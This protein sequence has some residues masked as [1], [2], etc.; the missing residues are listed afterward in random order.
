MSALPKQKFVIREAHP[1]DAHHL[2]RFVHSASYGLAHHY[3]QS[4]APEGTDPFEIG[5]ERAR[6]ETGS[7]SYRNAHVAER[8][9]QVVA[10]MIGYE[11]GTEPEEID[12][13]EIPAIFV[14]LVELENRALNSFY[15]NVLATDEAYQ[16]LGIGSQLLALAAELAPGKQLSLIC[17][18]GNPNAQKLYER[19][20]FSVQATRPKVKGD[21]KGD[22]EN[23]LLMIKPALDIKPDV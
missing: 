5:C 9:G 20:G 16:G 22:G 13:E 21:W 15:V 12:P 14:P 1:N 11:I 2:A 17:S 19:V 10:G 18:D 6:G 4:V 8:D 7:F 3:W 23:W